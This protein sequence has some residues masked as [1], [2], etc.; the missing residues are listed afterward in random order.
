M[1]SVF[2]FLTLTGMFC[3]V[4]AGG[5]YFLAVQYEPETRPET[6]AVPG[7]KIRK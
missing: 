1:P 3:A 4:I 5:L 2:R 7:L 6:K